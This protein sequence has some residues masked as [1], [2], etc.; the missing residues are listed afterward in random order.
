[1]YRCSVEILAEHKYFALSIPQRRLGMNT[2]EYRRRF[3]ILH[4]CKCLQ[5]RRYWEIIGT[6][7]DELDELERSVQGIA[8]KETGQDDS[9]LKGATLTRTASR[10]ASDFI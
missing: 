4:D 3:Y 5:I 1:M 7:H 10:L 2:I 6:L 9:T 8:I